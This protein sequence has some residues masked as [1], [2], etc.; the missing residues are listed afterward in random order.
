MPSAPPEK[1]KFCLITAIWGA[2]FVDLFLRVTVRTL[3]ADGNAAS[4]A[5]RY[6]TTFRIYTTAADA[7][8]MWR[9]PLFT[10]LAKSVPI[11]IETFD[12][13]IDRTMSTS[14]WHVWRPAVAAAKQRGE[15]VILIVPDSLYAEGALL[16]WAELF[17]QG[18]HAVW[19]S[20]PQVVQETTLPEIEGR[21]SDPMQ[22]IALS[23]AD[24][25]RLVIRHLHPSMISMFRDSPRWTRHPEAVFA[26]VPGQGLCFRIS[27]SHPF[28]FDPNWF[29]M[30]DAFSPVD[31]LD[32]ISF[33]ACRFASLEPVLK[34]SSHY[35][36]P[37]R[38]DDLQLSNLGSWIDWFYG[39]GNIRMSHFSDRVVAGDHVNK[40]AFRRTE[41]SLGI[42]LSQ[43]RIV[44]ALYR[45]VRA[46]REAGCVRAAEFVALAAVEGRLRR[47]AQLK[48][49]VTILVPSDRAIGTLSAAT[50]N[51]LLQLGRERDLVA[52]VLAHAVPGAHVLE[53]GQAVEAT[54]K[55]LAK[56]VAGPIAIDDFTIYIVDRVLPAGA[57]PAND[58]T[59]VPSHMDRWT[60]HPS[61]LASL[62]TH[63]R[64]RLRGH[65]RAAA[66]P[67]GR[68]LRRDAVTRLLARMLQVARGRF[69]RRLDSMRP[70]AAPPPT[71]A[72]DALAAIQAART[73][74]NLCSLFR[75]YRDKVHDMGAAPPPLAIIEA[76]A[77][78]AGLA[79]SRLTQSLTIL[80]AE[81]PGFADA[82]LELAETHAD[83]ND[84]RGALACA[85]RALAGTIATPI[86][87]GTAPIERT[88]AQIRAEAL[89]ALGRLEEAADTYRRALSR[90][91]SGMMSL[92]YGRL[93]RRLGQHERAL[94]LWPDALLFD[95]EV[96]NVVRLPEQFDDLARLLR[97][98]ST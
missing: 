92:R 16:H 42:Y 26:S 45:L 65:V 83:R 22:A 97:S 53:P 68:L 56:V 62:P 32:D 80:T 64:D 81:Y 72:A 20:G 61:R 3:L 33:D 19:S 84:H 47:H 63:W 51:R 52:A 88:A 7:E 17:A 74:L 67:G 46:L 36:R 4:L 93:L 6:P 5:A 38:M 69:K 91:R 21:T 31:R 98:Q 60:A 79:D 95:I 24:M 86:T 82:W 39:P 96:P 55:S 73:I 66:G 48:G 54:G 12:S 70:T 59:A 11:E 40:A 13:D 27:G 57:W 37:L 71:A 76:F 78:G 29:T 94:R 30:T 75:Y 14:H 41:Q 1:L 90:H 25:H 49:P 58:R 9:S 43:F 8:A 18:Y 44:G 35:Y 87:P 10:R 85:D 34:Y 28:C 50:R 77:A 2:R 89:V 23:V 15:N